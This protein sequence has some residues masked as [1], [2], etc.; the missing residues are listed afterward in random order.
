MIYESGDGP[1][2]LSMWKC[3]TPGIGIK[4]SDPKYFRRVQVTVGD[5]YL[6][7]T[8]HNGHACLHVATSP[9]YDG[10]TET[11]VVTF[12]RPETIKNALD[13]ANKLGHKIRVSL[14]DPGETPDGWLSF[15]GFD[16]QSVKI[17][18]GPQQIVLT[19]TGQK[20]FPLDRIADE[21]APNPVSGSGEAVMVYNKRMKVFDGAVSQLGAL[22][23]VGGSTM[24]RAVP[25]DQGLFAFE[26]WASTVDD[27]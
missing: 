6:A 24:V 26:G 21:F 9:A 1:T 12:Q 22:V 16:F 20:P 7:L 15:P 14:T 23:L 19:G 17:D 11:T 25:Q 10:P 4:S 13:D 8:T 3:V 27:D 2:L 18:A 5:D